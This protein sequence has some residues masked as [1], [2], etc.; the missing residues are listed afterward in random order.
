MQVRLAEARDAE[1]IRTIYNHEVLTGTSTFDLRERTTEE[2]RDWMAAHLGAHP[3]IVAVETGG[4]VLGFGALS[5]FRQRPAYTTTVENSVYVADRHRGQG[6]GRALLVELLRLARAT[7]FHTVIARI[8]G[9]NEGSIAL[10]RRCG[11]VEVGVEREIGRKF[12][13]WLDVVVLQ[14]MLDD[15]R[16]GQP[17]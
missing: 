9:H 6:V 17:S 4:E 16:S 13:Q 11:F 7:G 8:G 2:Q 5:P 12:G 14:A 1:A 3:A 15:P 10:H